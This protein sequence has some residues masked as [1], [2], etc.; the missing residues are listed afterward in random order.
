VTRPFL[1]GVT[2]LESFW[3][4]F[5]ADLRTFRRYLLSDKDV[6]SVEY[7]RKGEADGRD[8]V[9]S[10][11]LAQR[12]V[13]ICDSLLRNQI[14]VQN[15]KLCFSTLKFTRIL[16]QFQVLT[17]ARMRMTL[18]WNVAPCYVVEIDRRYAGAYC[19]CLSDDGGSNTLET[20]VS[21][22]ETKRRIIPEGCQ[23]SSACRQDGALKYDSKVITIIIII[24]TIT[25]AAA[26]E[27]ARL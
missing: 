11:L 2:A 18:C 6:T 12:R 25:A 5:L 26:A 14:Q 13:S 1:S 22:Y 10:N 16:V 19:I 20:S 9:H 23:S 24:I 7:V 3:R 4:I 8:V 15:K 27:T 21:C 17:A